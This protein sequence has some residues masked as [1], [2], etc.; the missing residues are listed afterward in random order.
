MVSAVSLENAD[1]CPSCGTSG[2]EWDENSFAYTPIAVQCRGCMLKEAYAAG[3][4]DA[5]PKGTTIRLVTAATAER[6]AVLA[7]LKPVGRPRRK[8]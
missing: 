7:E 5:L 1:R 2:H 3:E 8:G 4:G 6:L